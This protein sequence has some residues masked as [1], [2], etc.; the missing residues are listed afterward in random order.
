MINKY[1]TCHAVLSAS[2]CYMKQN[3]TVNKITEIKS[4]EQQKKEVVITGNARDGSFKKT[5]Y[6]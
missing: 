2:M 5:K 3:K 1:G 6:Q 4:E